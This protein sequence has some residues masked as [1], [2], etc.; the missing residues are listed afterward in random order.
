LQNLYIIKRITEDSSV[1]DE[2]FA[3]WCA[4]R[5]VMVKE[6]YEYFIS[7]NLL[8]DSLVGRMPTRYEV[9][10]IKKGYQELIEKGYVQVLYAYSK[11]EFKVDLTA[12]YYESGEYFS[13]LTKEEMCSIMNVNTSKVSR[14]KL[15]R[16][17]TCM[18][19]RF[20]R[21]SKLEK[22][23]RGKI[24]GM[25]MEC[26]EELLHISKN[27]VRQYNSLLEK[28]ELLFIIRHR[29]FYKW[30]GADGQ[31]N[32]REIPN[33]YSRWK[34]KELAKEYAGTLHGYK[35]DEAQKGKKSAEGNRKRG[36]AQKYNHF[37]AGK[38]YPAQEIKEIYEYIHEQNKNLISVAEHSDS[39][40]VS[41]ILAGYRSENCFAPY[42]DEEGE[43]VLPEAPDGKCDSAEDILNL[44]D[45]MFEVEWA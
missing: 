34:D 45:D 26:F 31:N 33:T 29:D 13:D 20:N 2:A 5:S 21:S 12:L 39:A 35:Y 32:V 6:T 17:F 16:Y 8:A 19:G 37:V 7:Y 24:G 27:T 25:S 42:L 43:F 3:V 30:R 41:T 38:E 23:Y 14:C 15:L 22:K 44:F 36:L 4:L 11:S 10:I 28:K 9:D 40:M 1:S 18:V